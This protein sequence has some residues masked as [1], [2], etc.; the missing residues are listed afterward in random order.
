[1]FLIEKIHLESS[2]QFRIDLQNG[3]KKFQIEEMAL[4]ITLHNIFQ[5]GAPSTYM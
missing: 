5:K 1:M 4:I 3:N 2:G